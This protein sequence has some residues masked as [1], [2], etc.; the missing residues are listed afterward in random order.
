MKRVFLCLLIPIS[1]KA[2]TL[3]WDHPTSRLAPPVPTAAPGQTPV[4]TYTGEPLAAGDLK[5]SRLYNKRTLYKVIPYPT[6]LAS[7]TMQTNQNYAWEVTAIDKGGLQSD[8]SNA[9]VIQAVPIPTLA[10]PPNE[11]GNLR[12]K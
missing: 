10:W 4:P 9:L 3:I 1:V 12:V 2:D 8:Y 6:N 7:V 5:E 11:P